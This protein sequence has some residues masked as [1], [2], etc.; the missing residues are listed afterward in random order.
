MA[1]QTTGEGKTN[2]AKQDIPLSEAARIVREAISAE[3]NR[4]KQLVNSEEN[5]PILLEGETSARYDVQMMVDPAQVAK[6]MLDYRYPVYKVLEEDAPQGIW[7]DLAEM[8]GLENVY[9]VDL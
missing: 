9:S 1:K 2:Q 4:L 3:E 7:D 6:I 5:E 8:V